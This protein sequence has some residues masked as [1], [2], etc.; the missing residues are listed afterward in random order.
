MADFIVGSAAVAVKPTFPDLQNAIRK[1]FSRA[2]GP[3]ATRAGREAGQ[4][5]SEA[6]TK[7]ARGTGKE[8]VDKASK[9]VKDGRRDFEKAAKHSTSGMDEQF[10]EAGSRSGSAFSGGLKKALAGVGV[11]IAGL[12][13]A[14]Q[15]RS[16]IEEASNVQQGRGA[17]ESVY[18]ASAKEAKRNA[19]GA[20]TN[21]GLS[22]S[23]YL[24][25]ATLM[26]TMGKNLLGVAEEDL[27]G[28]SDQQVSWASDLAAT[29]GG[30]TQEALEAISSM[31]R[32]EYNPIERY[33]V[34]VTAAL[35]DELAKAE[36]ISRAEAT[37][38][39]AQT[40]SADAQGM[41]A[42]ESDTYAGQMQ[43][44]S[45]N[46]D[47]IKASVGNAL[48]PSLTNLSTWFNDKGLPAIKDF[49]AYLRDE[50]YPAL[51]DFGA[52]LRD[53]V[54]PALK[55]VGSWFKDN[56]DTDAA[57]V[58]TFVTLRAAMLGMSIATAVTGWL[59]GMT[60]A[61][62]LLNTAMKANPILMIVGLIGTL[63]AGVIYAYQNFE[64][65]R[66]VVDKVWAG[67]K[68]AISF[69]WNRVIKPVFQAISGFIQNTL[70]PIF[71]WFYRNV[72]QPVWSGISWAIQVAW[73]AIKLVFDLIKYA[74]EN[75]LAPAF[76]WF[77]DTVIGPVW[78]WI[79]GKISG[80]WNNQIKPVLEAFGGF[81]ENTVVPGI[82]RGAE[83]IGNIWN[84]VRDMFARPINWVL[85]T[86]WNNGIKK[87][88]DSVAQAIGS[89]A[90]LPAA[91]RIPL[92]TDVQGRRGGPAHTARKTGG[93]TPAGLTL[94][95]EEGPEFLQLDHPSRV[96][97]AALTR[98][99]QNMPH[100]SGYRS[101]WDYTKA[102]AGHAAGWVRGN[103]AN[104]A[105]G[106]LTPLFARIQGADLLQNHIG[107]L[108]TGSAI[109]VKDRLIEWVRGQDQMK[110]L[111]GP[112]SK[113]GDPGARSIPGAVDY[114]NRAGWALADQVGGIRTL[115]TLNKS[116]A[117]GHRTG[118]AIDFWDAIPKLNA[119]SDAITRTG[120]FGNLKYMAWQ[121]QLW[122]PD[123]GWRA[124]GRG[125][126]NDPQH[127][128][129]LH[130]EWYDNGG[131]LMPGMTATMNGTGQPEAVFTNSQ[132][133]S[134]ST[135]AE[136]GAGASMPDEV[137]LNVDGE[138][139]KAYVDTRANR[140][141]RIGADNNNRY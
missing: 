141:V 25:S 109:N 101:A 82:R 119:L 43:R 20:A 17:A 36:G 80:I 105:D 98:R 67:I 86:V 114:V 118:K 135:L 40:Q 90:R 134:I 41:F 127:R 115:Q 108:V 78:D 46:L 102:G 54:Y 69:A 48:L 15:V 28:W 88:F 112:V 84:T 34:T 74:I 120:G 79:S 83:I 70:I 33:G 21:Y 51:K 77:K 50:V 57:V 87:V 60:L 18:G 131:W 111:S 30:S 94:V 71:Q 72:I 13:I 6:V 107:Q 61:Q 12:G 49:G 93:Y 26:G 110:M 89:D 138:R 63:V 75:Y 2:F 126:G 137:W 38:A 59:N 62:K 42:K 23:Q 106:I 29:Y 16:S 27:A 81:I 3:E 37:L 76:T 24:E 95:G 100:G 104:M 32:G 58:G 7:E 96:Y 11:M 122:S 117:G 5:M 97:N 52:N 128:R 4:E 45:A 64:G 56:K 22:E 130:A 139:F 1:E 113:A 85:D 116:M 125:Y 53:E 68:T 99:M 103:F 31:L 92:T 65:F 10:T 35:A 47:N 124:Q 123:S 19:R 39:L 133:Q 14:Q 136:R 66:N 132:W 8:F 44:L 140:A 73:N 129:H 55:D 91:G 9:E 121:G